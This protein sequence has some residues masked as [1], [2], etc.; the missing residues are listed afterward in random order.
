MGKFCKSC[1]APLKPDVKFCGVCGSAATASVPAQASSAAPVPGGKK[2]GAAKKRG[3]PPKKILIPAI[4]AVLVLALGIGL[5]PGLLNGGNYPSQKGATVEQSVR[6]DREATVGSLKKTG[7]QL[8]IPANAFDGDKELSM[9]VLSETDAG[10]YE[11][12]A[13]EFIGTPVSISVEG[14]EG[15]VWLNRP[16]TV[17]LQIPKEQRAADNTADDYLAAYF[18][19]QE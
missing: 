13:F 12:S 16:V 11:N 18:S 15:S 14:K 19:G 2:N 3:A 17:T 6:A 7:W 8:E 10:S 9:K 1:G 4:A 5:L